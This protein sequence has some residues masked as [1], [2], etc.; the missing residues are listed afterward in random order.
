M[1]RIFVSVAVLAAL[2]LLGG[3]APKKVAEQTEPT[4]DSQTTPLSDRDKARPGDK[5]T[6]RDLPRETITERPLDKGQA[7]EGSGSVEELQARMKDIFFDYDRYDIREDAKPVLREIA[8][9]LSRAMDIKVIVEGHCDSRGTNEYNLAL[10]DRRAKS[11]KDYLVS[12]GIS[13]GRIEVVSYGEEKPLC[14][15]ENETCW[16]KNRRAHFVLIRE[17]R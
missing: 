5:P 11:A 16:G 15:D 14:T 13:S 4:A 3:C 7:A 6:G 12:L 2:A 10:G 1:K 9:M 17:T 8:A